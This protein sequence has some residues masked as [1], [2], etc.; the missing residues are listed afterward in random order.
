[1][2]NPLKMYRLRFV[3]RFIKTIRDSGAYVGFNGYATG[4]TN[5]FANGPYYVPNLRIEGTAVFTNKSVAST[6]RGFAIAPVTFAVEAQMYK[7][8]KTIGM[9]PLEFRFKN[10][11]RRGDKLVNQQVM[12]DTSI[13]EVMQTLAQKAGVQLPDHLYQMTSSDRRE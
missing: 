3:A 13:I 7:I 1:M 6:M 11:M 8:A 9:D 4:K 5:F 2:T 12:H 10:A